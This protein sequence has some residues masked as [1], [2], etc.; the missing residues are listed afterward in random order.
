M[1]QARKLLFVCSHNLQRSITAER[2]YQGFKGYEARSAGT[3]REA[4]VRVS[5]EHLKWADIVFVMEQQHIQRLRSRFK[6][7]LNGKRLIC[8]EIPDRYGYM[9]FELIRELKKKLSVYIE[10][11]D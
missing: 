11:P 8:L 7:A 5:E 6:E 10:V 1:N 3:E 9:S 2:I 4:R